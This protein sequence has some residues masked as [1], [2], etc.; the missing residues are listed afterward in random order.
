MTDY[1]RAL[2]DREVLLARNEAR[3]RARLRCWLDGYDGPRP[4]YRIELTLNGDRITATAS[5]I[6]ESLAGLRHQLEPAGLMIAVQGARRDTYPSGMLRDMGDGREV[7]VLREGHRTTQDDIVE[8]LA[9][10]E[11][12][13]LGT[14]EEQQAFH[15]AWLRRK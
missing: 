13:Q 4:R 9:D 1:P 8:T 3:L 5:D 10:A 6:F 2:E 12:E 15:L 7:Y 11:V 14:V